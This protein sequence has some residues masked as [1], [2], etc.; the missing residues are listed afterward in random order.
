MMGGTHELIGAA[1]GVSVGQTLGLSLPQT[2]ALT[3]G[4][5]ASSRLPD[6]C[7]FDVLPHRKVT[8]CALA[9]V[10]LATVVVFGGLAIGGLAVAV[11]AG[12][13]LGYCVHVAADMCTVRGIPLFWPALRRDWWLLPRALRVHTDKQSEAVAA[14][15]VAVMLVTY[16]S[17]AQ[18]IV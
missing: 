3:V 15:L 12:L 4:A 7:E 1:A 6:A 8:H 11:G 16:L 10:A 2:A 17:V 18:G 9:C 13:A 14:G 5:F